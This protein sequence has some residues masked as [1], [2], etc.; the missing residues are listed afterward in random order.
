MSYYLVRQVLS[1]NLKRSFKIFTPLNIAHL[2]TLLE[3]LPGNLYVYLVNPENNSNENLTNDLGKTDF[4]F[5]AFREKHTQ[6]LKTRFRFGTGHSSWVGEDINF[7]CVEDPSSF[8]PKN[9]FCNDH[10]TFPYLNWLEA[11]DL[12]EFEN[13]PEK[14]NAGAEYEKFIGKKYEEVGFE[15]NYR[16]LTL[17]KQDGGIDLIAENEQKIMLVQCKNWIETDNYQID[18]RD[19]RAFIGDCYLYLIQNTIKKQVAF[20]YIISDYQMLADS[21]KQFLKKQTI[22]QLKETRFELTNQ[23]SASS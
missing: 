22:L 2:K 17:G 15:V 19:L 20:H 13:Q 16:G 9:F 18:S 5:Q 11:F 6:I 10:V 21:A 23:S 1:S 12:S 4:N 8:F 7:Y 3:H 14:V